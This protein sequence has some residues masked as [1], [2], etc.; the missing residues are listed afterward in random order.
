MMPFFQLRRKLSNIVIT[1]VIIQ[2]ILSNENNMLSFTKRISNRTVSKILRRQTTISSFTK[3]NMFGIS[4]VQAFST[5]ILYPNMQYN[6][7]K[8]HTLNGNTVI[9]SIHDETIE[10]SKSN[11]E[12]TIYALSSGNA[13]A[14][15]IT[16]LA[17]IRISGPN[18]LPCLNSLLLKDDYK[19]KARYATLRTI[20]DPKTKEELDSCIVLYFPNPNSFTG[21]DLIEFHVH[22]STAVI[23]GVLNALEGL[24]GVRPA[25][26]G[27]FTY[28]AFSN[29]KL[30]VL[31][32]EALYD[33]LH[34]Q[35]STQR[36]LALRQL[37][38]KQTH[39][40]DRM[41]MYQQWR[42]LLIRGMAH[43]EAI[44]DFGDDEHLDDD[45]PNEEYEQN[46]W[47]NVQSDI[48]LLQSQINNILHHD[49][50]EIIRNG[51]KIAIVGPPNA[52]KSSLLNILSKRDVAIVSPIAGTTRDVVEVHL[53]LNGVK[54]ILQDTAGLYTDKD[55]MN[56]E[57]EEESNI[58]VIEYQGIQRAK[59]VA[60]EANVI[61]GVLDVTDFYHG[62]NIIQ[63][64]SEK[65]QVLY[66]INKS[67]LSSSTNINDLIQDNNIKEYHTISCKT[68]DGI[69]TLLQKLST[70]TQTITTSESS[71]ITRTRHRHHLISANNALLNFLNSSSKNGLYGIDLAS[72]DLRLACSEIGRIVGVID[73]DDVLDV[74][75]QDFCIGK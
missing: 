13:N 52:G 69:D 55:I 65:K 41:A 72:E 75:F 22:G 28:R 66:V 43:A 2:Q 64:L 59:K 25:D 40:D 29:G 16:A 68:S 9:R 44:I 39:N 15:T 7:N 3:Y 10:E 31:Q 50:G 70:K 53:D 37:Q 49:V 45:L 21:E 35:T 71:I 26:A 27:E 14:N 61:I 51:I 32:V 63:N 48:L 5:S 73:V 57:N 4:T 62:W 34:S 33:L 6:R 12:E 46:V 38:P 11:E 56:Y 54:C 67:D 20:Y 36:S 17:I 30:N 58:D 74:L 60:S 23:S 24:D 1:W 42:T 8:Y 18:A 47:G 19:P